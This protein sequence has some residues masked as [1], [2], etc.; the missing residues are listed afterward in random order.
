MLWDYIQT[1]KLN[2][3]PVKVLKS[4]HLVTYQY[5]NKHVAAYFINLS[6]DIDVFN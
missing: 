3:I 4:T 5:L 2:I 6:V 1:L